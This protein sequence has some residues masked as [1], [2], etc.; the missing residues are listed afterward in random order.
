[1]ISLAVNIVDYI[2]LTE[3]D[4]TL[5]KCII[6]FESALKRCKVVRGQ[7]VFDFMVFIFLSIIIFLF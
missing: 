5:G 2:L 4:V 6:G 1:M 3:T 7:G